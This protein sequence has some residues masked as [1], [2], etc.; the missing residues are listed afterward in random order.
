MTEAV[1]SSPHTT[2][3][4]RFGLNARVAGHVDQ[5]DSLTLRELADVPEDDL[6]SLRRTTA[7]AVGLLLATV[8]AACGSSGGASGS[9]NQPATTA[10]PVSGATT[11]TIK[12]FAFHPAS[13]TV[14]PGTKVTFVQE[15]SVVHNATAT[16]A[17]SFKTPNL[18]VGQK[19]T[20]TFTKAGTY[21][22]ICTIHPT[23]MHGTIVV[24]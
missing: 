12:D 2:K 10:A 13:L 7:V 8:L 19:Y 1:V 16:G 21:H 4:P 14:T 5:V 11:V 24:T 20:V 17:N 9:S 3:P 22:Y 15:D 23:L 18:N 6:T